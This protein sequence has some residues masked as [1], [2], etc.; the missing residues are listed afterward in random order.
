[1]QR[2]VKS[3][4]R[5][6]A[7]YARRFHRGHGSCLGA[8]S[9]KKWYGTY[10]DKPDGVWDKNAEMMIEFSETAHPVFRASSALERVEL[11]SKGVSKNTTI[12]AEMI[13][14]MRVADSIVFRIN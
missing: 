8:G 2:N 13:T 14:E 7:N 5:Q 12:W 4:S 6:V 10:S 1:M 11:P 3:N 9:E